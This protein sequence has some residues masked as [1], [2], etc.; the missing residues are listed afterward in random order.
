L[1]TKLTSLLLLV[2]QLCSSQLT[3]SSFI[4]RG[5]CIAAPQ[6]EELSRFIFFMEND[7]A[8][9]GINTLIIRIDYNYEYETYPKLRDEGALSKNQVKQIV[10]A[11]RKNNIRLIPQINLLGHQSWAEHTNILLKEFPQFDETPGI[12][13]PEKYIWPNEDGL[14]CKSYCPLHPG[15]HKV[16]FALIDEIMGVFEADAFHA[17]MDEVFYIG[18]DECPRCKGKNKAELFAGEV[19]AVRNHLASKNRE[20]WIWGDRLLDGKTT[21]LGMWEASENNTFEAIDL[22]PGDVVICDWHYERAEP[23]A[24]IF[25]S[26]GFRVIACYYNKPEVTSAQLQLMQTF[27]QNSNDVLR[28]RFYGVMQTIWSPAGRFLGLYYGEN[29]D[30]NSMGPVNSYKEMIRYIKNK[31]VYP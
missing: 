1:K 23:T 30:E 8:P 29:P 17:G 10:E 3:D 25:A 2:Y 9:N 24:A 4:V 19:T 26:K 28:D 7:L 22:I 5:F 11:A 18:D 16:I 31:E 12:Q 6:P 21:G 14:Y 13:M 15:L 27:R 20:L